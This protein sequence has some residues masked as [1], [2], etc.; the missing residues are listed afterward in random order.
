MKALAITHFPGVADRLPTASRQGPSLRK[1][2]AAW[3][4]VSKD[5]R[6]LLALDDRLL[7][8]M[9]LT[10]EQAAWEASRPFWHVNADAYR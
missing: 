4:R 3:Y 7:A 6:R 5:R 9:G 8:D 10:R 2:I 1:R